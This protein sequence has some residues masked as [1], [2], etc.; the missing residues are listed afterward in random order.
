MVLNP[1]WTCGQRFVSRSVCK[2]N[3]GI[4]SIDTYSI[5]RYGRHAHTYGQASSTKSIS[6][7][8]FLLLILYLSNKLFLVMSYAD[9][10]P[11]K[12][13]FLSH[14]GTQKLI[15]TL[16]FML[17]LWSHF[18]SSEEV[19]LLVTSLFFGF[20]RLPR[21]SAGGWRL[22]RQPDI[23]T[24]HE[25]FKQIFSDI[26]KYLYCFQTIN[27]IFRCPG[28]VVQWTLGPPQKQKTQVRIPPGCKV[29]RKT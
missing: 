11:L 26:E 13:N 17:D 22:L 5:C 24:L 7:I 19:F 14:E 10:F 4:T 2:A 20:E 23:S 15:N 1:T 27:K 16:Y 3:S 12:Q 29:C 25:I 9:T 21:W 8:H 6:I 18:Y 28:G